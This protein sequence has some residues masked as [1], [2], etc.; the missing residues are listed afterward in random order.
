MQLP[1]PEFDST[2]TLNT[3]STVFSLGNLSPPPQELEAFKPYP[4][5]ILP[6]KLYMGNYVQAC[7]SQ[8]Q[9]DLKIKAHINVC[10]EAGT[11]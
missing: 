9:K 4:V 6:A 1:Q 2:V 8:I 10:E 11:L 3:V 7:D 5:E